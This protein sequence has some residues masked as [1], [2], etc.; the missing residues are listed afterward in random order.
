MSNCVDE[1]KNS[2]YGKDAAGLKMSRVK[3]CYRKALGEMQHREK[4]EAWHRND[5][6]TALR[7]FWKERRQEKMFLVYF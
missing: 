2:A 7:D 1:C 6:G 5:L 4:D 3:F